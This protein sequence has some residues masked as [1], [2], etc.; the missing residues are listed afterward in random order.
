MTYNKD[1]L[2]KM[3]S[4]APLYEGMD[5]YSEK[6]DQFFN[7]LGKD[8]FNHY[9][10][11]YGA[12][13][14]TLI[15]IDDKKDYVIKIPYT[16][17]YIFESEEHSHSN[18]SSFYYSDKEEYWEF[19]GAVNGDNEWDYC[20][21]EANRFCIAE[22][23]G[24]SEYFA[25]TELLGYIN[26][27]PIYVQEKCITLSNCHHTH[28]HSLEEREKTSNCCHN[29][30]GIDED[31]L[32]DF[33]LYYGEMALINFINFIYEAG[34]DDDLRNDNIGYLNNRPVLIDYSGFYD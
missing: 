13:K 15:P 14:L 7:A 10:F 3:L 4:I 11:D 24:F 9:H 25:K 32:T 1:K 18:S 12:S 22:E 20:G 6:N 26:N 28:N 16:G 8:F 33:R 30:C 17:S 21:C 5:F 19:S 34:W 27:Y 2:L 31:W 29:Y 23:E